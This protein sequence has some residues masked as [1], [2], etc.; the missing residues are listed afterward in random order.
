MEYISSADQKTLGARYQSTALVVVALGASVVVYL[1]IGWLITPS[2]SAEAASWGQAFYLAALVMGVS[3]VFLRRL[4]LS[5][6]RLRMAAQRGINALLSN[7][8]TTSIVG[9]ALGDAVAVLGLLAY[10]LTGETDYCWRL[11]VIGL[12]L[13]I[14]SFPRRGEWLRAVSSAMQG[15]P[16]QA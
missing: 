13:I 3:V 1:V 10:L 14:Y 6:L 5:Q 8:S 4:M 11:G 2:P 12:L 9:A 15:H 7:L 16:R